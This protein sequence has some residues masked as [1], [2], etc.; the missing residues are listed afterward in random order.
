[1]QNMMNVSIFFFHKFN[2]GTLIKQTRA[3][4][5]SVTN[6][7]S[8][9]LSI[10]FGTT[11]RYLENLTPFMFFFMEKSQT[12]CHILLSN[13]LIQSLRPFI[14][15]QGSKM[16]PEFS[17]YFRVFQKGTFFAHPLSYNI[18]YGCICNCRSPVQSSL[19]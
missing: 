4:I 16:G 1:M 18:L 5:Y 6:R 11:L 12:F 10:Q 19:D 13:Y 9:N 17:R 8:P 14:R 7:F 15:P 3:L 2:F